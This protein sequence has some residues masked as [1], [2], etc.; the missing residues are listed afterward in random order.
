MSHISTNFSLTA[1]LIAA[2][3]AIGGAYN[4]LIA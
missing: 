4:P 3:N 1:I 2:V